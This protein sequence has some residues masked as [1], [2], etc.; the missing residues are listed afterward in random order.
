MYSYFMAELD[1]NII[2]FLYH[3]TKAWYLTTGN[4]D[5]SMAADALKMKVRKTTRGVRVYTEY[6]Q[7]FSLAMD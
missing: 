5:R 1:R 7:M 4:F 2:L 3:R 6:F